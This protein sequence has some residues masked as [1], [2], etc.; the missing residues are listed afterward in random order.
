MKKI[1]QKMNSV[2]LRNSSGRFLHRL[3]FKH[4]GFY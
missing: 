2:I 1:E 4:H 3:P